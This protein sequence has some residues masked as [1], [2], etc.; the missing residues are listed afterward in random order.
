VRKDLLA[1]LKSLSLADYFPYLNVLR[2]N[3]TECHPGILA[4]LTSEKTKEEKIFQYILY[5]TVQLIPDLWKDRL[6]T[7][8]FDSL[9]SMD[10]LDIAHKV[11]ILMEY[12]N[13][14]HSAGMLLNYMYHAPLKR[15]LALTGIHCI[16]DLVTLTKGFSDFER[17]CMGY[18]LRRRGTGMTYRGAR[19][20]LRMGGYI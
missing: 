14:T 12:K 16:A 7:R 20:I 2:Y 10:A 17:E 8:K 6:D 11:S 1:K 15:D 18:S 9:I 19:H 5:L 4:E 3:I 13:P